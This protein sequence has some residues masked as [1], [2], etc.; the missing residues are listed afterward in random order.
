MYN[1][2]DRKLRALSHESASDVGDDPTRGTRGREPAAALLDLVSCTQC[3]PTRA[4][5]LRSHQ[6]T[7]HDH[8]PLHLNTLASRWRQR[9]VSPKR[10]VMLALD[11]IL[12][13]F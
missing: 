9:P 3:Q 13:P 12:T 11:S 1:A 7:P 2:C 6:A 5:P 10:G 8:E 4:M